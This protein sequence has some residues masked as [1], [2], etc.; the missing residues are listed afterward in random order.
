[1]DGVFLNQQPI[2][3]LAAST[4]AAFAEAGFTERSLQE[5][6]FTL[7]KIVRL[8]EEYGTPFYNPMLIQRFISETENRYHEQLIGRM[9]YRYLLKTVHYLIDFQKNG[10]ICVTAGHTI[11]NGLNE[12]YNGILLAICNNAAWGEATKRCLRKAVMPYLKWLQ[13]AGC[14]SLEN[15]TEQLLRRYLMEISG[16]MTVQSIDTIRRALKKLHLYMFETGLSS[17]SYQDVLS[18]TVPPEHRIQKPAQPDDVAAVLG[19][20]DRDT[21]KGKRDYAMI[22]LAAVLGLRSIDIVTLCLDEINWATGEIVLKQTKTGKWLALPLMADVGTALQDYILNARPKTKEP[23]VFLRMR[24]P[25]TQIGSS[26]PYMA[27]KTYAKKAGLPQMQFHGLRRMLG[28]NLVIEGIPVTTVA[29][30][31]GHSSIEPTKQY[32]SLDSPRLKECA[33]GFSGLP[34]YGGERS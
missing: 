28:T 12:Y 22:L 11:D 14:H 18:F 33:L 27:L 2:A 7:Q 29:Q 32:V 16:R 9:R 20:I 31:L 15:L 6:K 26:I 1:M 8:H 21:P 30:I 24:S 34:P 25:A 10:T 19:V 3:T 5:R 4:L 13:A 17:N 23:Y